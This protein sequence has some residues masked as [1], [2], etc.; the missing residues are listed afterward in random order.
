MGFDW[1]QVL[2]ATGSGLAD[3]FDESSSGALYENRSAAA[4][5]G[6]PVDRADEAVLLPFQEI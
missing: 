3:V 1:E 5:P 4:P 2:G 6:T